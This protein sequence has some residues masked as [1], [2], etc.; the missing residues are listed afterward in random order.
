[1]PESL[2]PAAAPPARISFS[3]HCAEAWQIFLSNLRKPNGQPVL[4]RIALVVFLI[5]AMVA[6]GAY[7]FWKAEAIAWSPGWVAAGIGVIALYDGF[8]KIVGESA[9]PGNT[10]DEA[11]LVAL[12][13]MRWFLALCAFAFSGGVA[14]QRLSMVVPAALLLMCV[15]LV[16]SSCWIAAGVSLRS[17]QPSAD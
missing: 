9:S 6:C 17:E 1:V 12:R 4:H 5:V 16:V 3:K 11:A 13:R 2:E 15:S 8:A 10:L 14:A 7:G